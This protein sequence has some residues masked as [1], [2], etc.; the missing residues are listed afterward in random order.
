MSVETENPREE[1]IKELELILEAKKNI[2]NLLLT[3]MS[4]FYALNG[5]LLTITIATPTK[6]GLLFIP[7]F[8]IISMILFSLIVGRMRS[9][10]DNCDNRA[11][12]IEDKIGFKVIKNYKT[13]EC[14]Y[15]PSWLYRTK[16]HSTIMYFNLIIIVVWLILIFSFIFNFI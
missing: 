3:I 10:N 14:P 13:T 12:D 7:I 2:N 8:G 1:L 9:T 5:A 15:K 11:W 6:P 16:M 4:I